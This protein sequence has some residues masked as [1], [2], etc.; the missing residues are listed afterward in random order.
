MNNITKRSRVKIIASAIVSLTLIALIVL[1]LIS[2][3]ENSS[4][5]AMLAIIIICGLAIASLVIVI[6]SRLK[7]NEYTKTF[8]K[9][10]YEAFEAVQD[11]LKN[12]NLTKFEAKEVISDVTSMLYHAQKEGRDINDVVGLDTLEFVKKIEASFG[13]RNSVI[14]AVLNGIMYLAFVLVLMQFAVFTMRDDSI[15]FFET[16]ISVSIVPYMILLSF[17]VIPIM[18]KYI[19]KQKIGMSF[20]VVGALVVL[21]FAAH[22]MFYR[23]DHS[24][25][26]IDRYLNGEFVFLSSYTVLAIVAVIFMLC[27]GLKLY[28]RQQSIK[29]L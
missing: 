28:L 17:V 24:I 23:I 21:Y 3:K 16:Q 4:K 13:K 14:Y 22:E 19:A 9:E 8:S 10:Y 27:F 1:L 2:S 18:R 25:K 6:V 29:K 5:T 11:G 26:W 7:R 15:P 12:S 20:A